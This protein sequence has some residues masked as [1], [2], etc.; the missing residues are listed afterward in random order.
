[1]NSTIPH[2]QPPI[3]TSQFYMWRAVIAVAHADDLVQDAERAYL[4]RVI[5]NMDRV[6][7]LTDDQKSIF[8]AD[9]E[10]PQKISDLLPYINDPQWR[11]QLIYFAGM[12][13]H[14]D[15][16]LDPREDDIIKK[17][18]ADQMASLHL[19]EIRAHAK[20]V[21]ADELFKHEM[22][23]NALRPQTGLSGL[24]DAFLLRLGIDMMA[25]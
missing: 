18:R 7:G 24:L 15:G 8:A 10:T 3:S 23:L 20:Q 6:N 16:T 11:G 25:D 19:D 1:M 13:A 2:A 21:T 14:A 12:L 4:N 17:L 22:E 5:A 9:I